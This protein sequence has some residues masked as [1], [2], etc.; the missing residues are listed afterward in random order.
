MVY[1]IMDLEWNNAYNK[2]QKSFVNEIL[3]IGAVMVNDELEVIDTFSVIIRSQLSKKLNGRVKRLTHISNEDMNSGVG[4]KQAF[5]MFRDW[6][7][8]RNCVFLSWSNSDIRVL[9][10]NFLMFGRTNYI[11]FLTQYADLQ[12]YCQKFIVAPPSRQIGLETAAEQMGIDT[13]QLR[14][15][16]ALEDCLLELRCLKKCYK[17][18]L[19]L[20][21]A[22][23]CD[24]TF[25][26]K[27]LFKS[28][29]ISNINN[30]KVD[31]SKMRCKCKI[32]GR[33]MSRLTEWTF[34][35]QSF[36]AVF[37]CDQCERAVTYSVRFKEYYDKTDVRVSE[38][39]MNDQ[40]AD[41]TKT[42]GTD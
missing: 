28:Y 22:V 1:V 8:S 36:N 7:G 40:K 30:P 14:L 33:Q 34:K 3:E 29:I 16:R 13:S 27:L 2:Y 31:K 32:C 9:Y 19:L 17:K 42:A 10:D 35:H 12:N 23:M 18:D 41:D 20:T 5:E 21:M 11:P 15:H 24:S 37:A 6:I 26:E 39:E 25:Y 4:F 38:K